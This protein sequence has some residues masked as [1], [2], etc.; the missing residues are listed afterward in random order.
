MVL[1]QFCPIPVTPEKEDPFPYKHTHCCK[2]PHHSVPS[3]V[4]PGALILISKNAF[5][6]VFFAFLN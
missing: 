5:M 1:Y 2:A 3:S 6:F 4:A